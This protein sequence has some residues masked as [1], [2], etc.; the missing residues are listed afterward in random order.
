M[1]SAPILVF[2]DADVRPAGDML[3]RVVTQL[4]SAA[5][6]SVAPIVS[7]Q[8]W[9]RTGT[10]SE[11]ASLLCNVTA[12]MGSGAFTVLPRRA[13]PMAFGP[14]LA[15][16][17]ANYDRF[18]GHAAD[19]VRRSHTEDIAM[20]RLAGGAT[21]FTGRPDTTFRMYPD[22]LVQ[23]LNGWTRTLATGA[24]YTP[25]WLMLAILVWVASLAG[26]WVAAPAVYPLSALQVWVLGRRA[27]SIHP[28]TA[29][30]YPVAVL[31]LA[32]VF[33]RSLLLTGLRRR[34]EW[35]GRRVPA[36]PGG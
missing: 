26:G 17:R 28:L 31:V 8:P 6:Q 11:Q 14:V 18:G 21:L 3:D 34:V 5:Q 9:H 29:L 33:V 10:A 36:R 32:V 7:V 25:W 15:I 20:A 1:T 19:A 23:T 35:K 4:T 30:F 22:G 16:S 13:V 24:R 2:L 27:G 12:L